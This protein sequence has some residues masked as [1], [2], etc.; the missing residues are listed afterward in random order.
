MIEADRARRSLEI[1]YIQLYFWIYCLMCL[2]G[3]YLNL[4]LKRE[5][6]LTGTQIG[7]LSG[8]LSAAGVILTPLIGLRFD[9]S[10][11]RPAFLSNLALLAGLA[12]CL[13]MLPV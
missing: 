5:S 1:R 13:Y 8:S 3:T 7:F 10:R 9:A 12:F 6:G 4:F 2:N 11:R